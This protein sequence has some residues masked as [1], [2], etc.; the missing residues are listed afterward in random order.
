MKASDV[1]TTHLVTVLPDVGIK[2]VARTLVQ[3]GISAVPVVDKAGNLLGIVSEGDLMHRAE[4]KTIEPRS[5]WLALFGADRDIAAAYVKS[6]SQRARDV[7][8]PDVVTITPETEL[9]AIARLFEKHHIKRVPV[10]D[11]G[12]LVG[13]VSRA[14]LVQ[15]IAMTSDGIP[16]EETDARLRREI[17]HKLK[18]QPW[19]NR[20]Y[21]IQVRRGE[22]H[23]S[24]FVYSQ[25]E[26]DAVRVAAEITPGISRVTN[27]LRVVARMAE[28]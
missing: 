10:L 26:R 17:L 27:D 1:M 25:E 4:I 23:L 9:S 11:H 5:W 28:Y 15:A 21:S 8:T 22:A 24:G 18:G 20:P 13:I 16:I 6:H 14:N 7:M 3:N 2:E 12:R 19:E